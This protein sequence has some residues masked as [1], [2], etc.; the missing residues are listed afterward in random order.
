MV[1]TLVA[2]KGDDE[3]KLFR[4]A[5]GETKVIGRSS[6]CD[7]ALR[8]I[9]I[10]RQHCRIRIAA[11]TLYFSDLE[12]KN[13]TFINGKQIRGEVTL[14]DGDVIDLAGSRLVVQ[15]ESPPAVEEPQE[16]AAPGQVTDGDRDGPSVEIRP[17]AD[18]EPTVSR[19]A[20]T[21][22]ESLMGAFECYLE[23][24]FPDAP[25]SE[26]DE[27]S[28][29]VQADIAAPPPAER[30]IGA[31]IG[32]CLIQELIGE[33]PISHIY[34]GT[35][36]SMERPVALKLLLPDMTH[37]RRVV[38]QFIQ[39]ARAAGKLSH[40]NIVQVYD[41][42]EAEGVYF[43]ALELVDGR[44]VRQLLEARSPNKGLPL[45]Q[46]VEIAEQIAGALEYAHSHSVIH[47]HITPDQILVTRHGIAKL[48]G[49]GF[50]QSLDDSAA[51]RPDPPAKQMER[52][53]FSAPEVLAAPTP[54]TVRSD[55]YSL[56][57][58]LFVIVTGIAPFEGNTKSE[59][60]ERIRAGEHEPLTRPRDKVPEALAHIVE[61]AMSPVPEHR[62]SRASELQA[63]LKWVRENL[64]LRL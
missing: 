16:A 62:H 46:A 40:P 6:R 57:A 45:K 19:A 54:A 9:G 22:G 24:R 25:P 53:C 15:A 42:G 18:A 52:L 21:S 10:S 12:S 13:G 47:R 2:V 36:V 41:A 48:A 63:E 26:G 44:S 55:I 11:G 30:F 37:N 56:G 64:R 61:R 60:V 31:T 38:E 1:V 33:D 4:L 3:G 59:I 7:I 34:R 29:G 39:A 35:Q 28:G 14:T 20:D 49:L 27:R 58:V 43:V 8:D 23:P 17:D 51:R 50:A 5:E 32:G